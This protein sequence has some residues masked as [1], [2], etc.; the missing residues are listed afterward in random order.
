[1]SGQA[2]RPLDGPPARATPVQRPALRLDYAALRPGARCGPADW[3]FRGVL[4]GFLLFGLIFF[5]GG[6]AALLTGGGATDV[7]L[8]AVS[9]ALF[10]VAFAPYRRKR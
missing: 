6:L 1:V 3:K 8:L 7:L 5:G 2:T 4:S 9:A 10:A